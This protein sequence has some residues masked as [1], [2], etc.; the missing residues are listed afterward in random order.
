MMKHSFSGHFPTVACVGFLVAS[1]AALLSSV[2]C[3]G[4]TADPGTPATGQT[5]TAAG[6]PDRVGPYQVTT[7]CGMVTDIVRVV[8]GEHAT[9]A[10]LIGEGIDPHLFTAGRDDVQALLSADVVFYSGLMLEGRMADS[11]AQVGR[12]GKPVYAVTEGLD[13]KLLLEPPEFE[14]HW[15]PHVWM[16]VSAWSQCAGFAGKALAEFDAAHADVYK[17]NADAYQTQLAE[18][19]D[20][21]QQVIGSIPEKSRYLVTAHDAFGYFGRA[22]GI[23]VKAI[24][25]ISTES[26]A[27]IA[28]INNLVDFIIENQ[29][30]AIF[31]ESSVSESNIK[32]VIVGCAGRDW[33]LKIGAELF[34]DAMGAPGTYEGTYI[35][36]MDHNATKI[37]RALGGE[38]PAGGWQ[39]KLAPPE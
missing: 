35:G 33:E 16:D 11:F 3:G 13:K 19:H 2:G 28:D 39:G 36:M 27:G 1:T 4:S 5:D 30:P 23:E 37:A 20:Y 7:T 26:Q 6:Q 12:K 25:G 21:C 9:V 10:G 32:A 31:V 14:G 24:Q 22:Y 34:S 15:D 18:L 17:A 38:A 8:A 29:V